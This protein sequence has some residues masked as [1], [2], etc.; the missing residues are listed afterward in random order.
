MRSAFAVGGQIGVLDHDGHGI[1]PLGGIPPTSLDGKDAQF[2]EDIPDFGDGI[3]RI[4]I[5]V[6]CHRDRVNRH[7]LFYNNQEI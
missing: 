5:L 6:F 2:L 3:Q 4:V 7:H 1:E